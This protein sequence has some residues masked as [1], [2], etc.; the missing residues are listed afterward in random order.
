MEILEINL[1]LGEI[2]YQTLMEEVEED[3]ENIER[4]RTVF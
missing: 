2:I 3:I 4:R 1:H